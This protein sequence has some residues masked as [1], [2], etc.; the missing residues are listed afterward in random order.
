MFLGLDYYGP[1]SPFKRLLFCS[2]VAALACMGAQ[3]ATPKVQ[4]PQNSML[5]REL[6]FE[7]L[8]GELSL[9]DGDLGSAYSLTLDAARKTRS[10][11]LYER[12]VE[13]ALQGRNG[14]SAL[15]AVQAW[16]QAFPHSPEAARYR[17]QI[18]IGM[19]R[20]ADTAEPLK[21]YLG[22]VPTQERVAAIDMVSRMFSRAADKKAVSSVLEDA[23][24]ADLARH[25]TGPAAWAAIGLARAQSGATGEALEAARRGA[26]LDPKSEAPA[27]LAL[28]LMGPNSPEAETIL[29]GYLSHKPLPEMR[30]AYS[31]VLLGEQRYADSYAQMLL[32]SSEKPDFADAWLVRGTLELQDKKWKQSESSLKTYLHLVAAADGQPQSLEAQRGA[33]QAYLLLA[34]IAEQDKRI[35]EAQAY[36]ARIDSP[37]DALRV[38]IR[39]STMLAHQGKLDE[40]RTGL[41]NLPETQ[42]GDARVK[43]NAEVQL[44]RDMKQYDAAYQLLAKALVQFPQDTDLSYDQAMLAEKLGKID[45]MER[46]LR[47]IIAAKPDHYHAYNALGYSLADRGVRLPEAR[48]LIDKALEFAPRDPYII[49]SL[50]WVEFRAGNPAEAARLLQGAYES[51]PDAEIA[52]H[53]GEVL[54][55]LGQREKALSF[56]NE[57][58]KLNPENETLIE[59]QQRL[60]SKP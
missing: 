8:V 20:I 7:I 29:K 11:K 23:L 50:A 10:A 44:L 40:A 18:L 1:M 13:V 42:P 53:L 3:A 21:R 22:T 58:H 33:V 52:A 47:Q 39:R 6:F 24:A 46:L 2:L 37:Q 28:A 17:L 25:S 43:L 26:A 60:R 48:Q 9:Q 15:E 36:L 49:D 31:R 51:R 19:N 35:D 56:W 12:A 55:T 32:L 5:D 41:R 54:W 34:E 14:A 57:G 59:T 30:M 4:P 45:E 16:L 38:Q 27:L